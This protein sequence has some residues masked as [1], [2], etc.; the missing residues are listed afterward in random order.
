MGAYE[1]APAATPNQCELD[2]NCDGVVDFSDLDDRANGSFY[3]DWVLYDTYHDHAVYGSYVEG[4]YYH[5]AHCG[6]PGNLDWDGNGAVEYRDVYAGEPSI[7]NLDT[8]YTQ[9]WV[10]VSY[11]GYYAYYYPDSGCD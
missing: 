10:Y 2:W 8:I 3:Q 5:K 1:F 11:P 7:A 6:Q 4:G 9:Y